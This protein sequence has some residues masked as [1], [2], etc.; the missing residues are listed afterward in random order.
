MGSKHLGSLVWHSAAQLRLAWQLYGV[1]QNH[2]PLVVAL[3][4]DICDHHPVR[5]GVAVRPLDLRDLNAGE[6]GEI[7]KDMDL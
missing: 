2:R 6:D 1:R 7:T 4:K 5:R 3:A